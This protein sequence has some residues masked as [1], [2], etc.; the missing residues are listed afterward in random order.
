MNDGAFLRNLLFVSILLCVHS[1]AQQ[2]FVGAHGQLKVQGNRIVNKNGQPV[3]LHGMSMY[4]WA[5]QGLQFYNATAIRR[6]V[7]EWK[8]TVI[9]IPILPNSVSSQTNLVKTVVDACIANG[10]YAIIDWHS[11]GNANATNCANFMKSMATQYGNTPNVMYEPWNEPVKENWPTIKSYMETVI[12]AIRSIDPDNIIICG[13]PQWDQ[14]PHLAAE[15][16]ITSSTNIAY[17]MHF[18]SATHK[19]WLRD[20]TEKALNKGIAIFATEYGLCE[21]TG[22][23]KLDVDET[24]KYWEFM[25][26][27]GIG[28]TNWSV[29]AISETSAAFNPGTS[30]TNWTDGNLKPSGRAVKEYIISKYEVPVGVLPGELDRAGHDIGGV[31]TGFSLMI[32]AGPANI[33]TLNGTLISKA[34]GRL[35]ANGLFIL[36]NPEAGTSYRQIITDVR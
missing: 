4:P 10:I 25:D 7:Q 30:S 27:N 33:F 22:N 28:C 35:P 34:R 29:C 26:A 1:S 2:T 32:G 8:C 36:K 16:P 20:N 23:G 31:M 6:L 9:R 15:N 24:K 21:S 18:Y 11:M 13:T 17:T 5:Q 14:S 19:Q 3:T 12:A